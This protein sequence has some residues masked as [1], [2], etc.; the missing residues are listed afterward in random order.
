MLLLLDM[1]AKDV[2]RELQSLADPEK[3]AV[4]QRFFKPG[5][6]QYGEGDIFLGVIVPKSR[7]VAKRFS[8][9]PLEEINALLY[10]SI[11]EERL[12]ALLILARKYGS[13]ASG[14]GERD[15]K[16]LP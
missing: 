16:V 4:L 8:Q 12:V 6:G 14:G 11:H 9:L 10:S 1:Q 5:P 7:E 15:H 3:A 2:R 13:S